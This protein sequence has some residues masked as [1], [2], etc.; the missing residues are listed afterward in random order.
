MPSATSSVA[1]APRW[2]AT[3]DGT[4]TVAFTDIVAS[5][6]RL[7][8]LGE[9]RWLE[10]LRAHNAVVT[11]QVRAHGG[12]EVKFTG[13]GWMIVF[14]SPDDAL[15]CAAGI[16][17]ALAER[18]RADPATGFR[19]RIGLHCGEAIKE[20]PDFLGLAVIVASRI[21]AEAAPDEVLASSAVRL[22][23]GG[24]DFRFGEGRDVEIKGLGPA[25][26][27]PATTGRASTRTPRHRE[28]NDSAATGRAS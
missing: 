27:F 21:T 20:G 7:L 14:A 23:T 13:D 10:A 5:T 3:P 26:V 28:S 1:V 4:V 15:R 2:L 19:V 12:A 6:E 24:G 16:Q 22:A 9:A 17:R 25:R 18:R 11:G 8:E